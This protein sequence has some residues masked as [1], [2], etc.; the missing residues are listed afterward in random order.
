ML[1]FIVLSCLHFIV[2]HGFRFDNYPGPVTTGVP[3]T[4]SWHRD[5]NDTGE[6]RFATIQGKSEEF[7]AS[8][9]TTQ[10]DGTLDVDFPIPGLFS[11]RAFDPN[12]NII[13]TSQT[14]DVASGS[15]ESSTV[16]SSSVTV[17]SA[18]VNPSTASV[19]ETR[20][21]HS[22]SMESAQST[23]LASPTHFSTQSVQSPATAPPS[24]NSVHRNHKT[25]V[26]IG[27][28]IGSLLFLLIIF[29]GGTFLFIRKRRHRHRNLKHRLS[30]N[31]KIIPELN[32]HS[33][34]VTNKND[35]AIT[36]MLP[37]GVAP[38][39]GDRSQETVEQNP[40]GNPTRDEGE[41]RPRVGT[42]VHVDNSEPQ[43]APQQEAALDVVAEVV[44]LR[45]QVQQIIVEREAER[46]HGNALDPPPAYA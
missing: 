38:D 30:P 31:L 3:I 36:P 34:P 18:S 33:P 29:G 37:G 27:A 41:R 25:P 9:Q 4:L 2:S 39:L 23:A 19:T 40:E 17:P 22:S 28:V 7:V 24:S 1:R 8:T 16:S 44:R 10:S 26:I 43:V 20:Q 35:E 21:L 42:P 15:S 46:F 5:V 6:I 14:F 11:V 13:A 32:S 12:S 45:T